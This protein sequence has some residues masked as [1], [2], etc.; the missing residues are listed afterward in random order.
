MLNEFAKSSHDVKN[1]STPLLGPV[2]MARLLEQECPSEG[3]SSGAGVV[4]DVYGQGRQY[5]RARV[6][7]DG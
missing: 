1:T 4:G 5:C 6:N 7:V 3:S 2:V